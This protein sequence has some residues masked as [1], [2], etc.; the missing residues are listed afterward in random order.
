MRSAGTK[1]VEQRRLAR[2][3]ACS[4]SAS[5]AAGRPRWRA[6]LAASE[7]AAYHFT[8]AEA[9]AFGISPQLL[10]RQ[11]AREALECA[12]PGVYRFAHAERTLYDPYVA[13]WLWSDRAAV[14][15]EETALQ[16][17]AL[18]DAFPRVLHL[19]VPAGWRPRLLPVPPLYVL[20]HG[21]VPVAER[22]WIGGAPVTSVLRTLQDVAS[23]PDF[24]PNLLLQ[25]FWDAR[26]EE[27]ITDAEYEHLASLSTWP[28]PPWP[29][30]R[31]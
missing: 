12:A 8:R 7:A 3:S 22:V 31:P 19:V 25:A 27:R 6:L 13:A 15:A 11:V 30:P 14:I 1:L 2:T 21:D 26:V 17:H 28:I 23:A 24:D 5:R 10:R 20:H 9:A 18:S 4:C 16:L 29:W